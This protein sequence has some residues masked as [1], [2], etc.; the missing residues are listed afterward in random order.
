M[1]Q[2]FED[3]RQRANWLMACPEST[4]SREELRMLLDE[5]ERL[6]K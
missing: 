4:A 6:V 1:A 2:L 3:A 5:I